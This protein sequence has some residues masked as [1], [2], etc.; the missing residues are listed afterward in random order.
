MNTLLVSFRDAVVPMISVGWFFKYTNYQK[1]ELF[2]INTTYFSERGKINYTN[3]RNAI[4]LNLM[5]CSH[6]QCM[7]RRSYW[8]QGKINKCQKAA[9]FRAFSEVGI[10][11]L[12]S[13][14]A[15]LFY[16]ETYLLRKCVSGCDLGLDNANWVCGLDVG[17]F[18]EDAEKWQPIRQL[19]TKGIF[20]Q[21][22]RC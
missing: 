1:V 6:K 20:G 5:I 11:A 17:H 7:S 4:F 8:C 9:Y 21:W 13:E 19:D 16:M 12:T 15:R 10:K 22:I 2:S 18:W 3:C 14:K